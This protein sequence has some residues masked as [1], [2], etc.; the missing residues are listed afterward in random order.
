MRYGWLFIIPLVAIVAIVGVLYIRHRKLQAMKKKKNKKITY[1][2]IANT[3]SVRDLPEYKSARRTYRTLIIL[4]TILFATSITSL[5]VLA[6]R[7]IEITELRSAKENRDVMLCLDTSYSM[8]DAIGE[9]SEYFSS[10]LDKLNGERIGI[11]LFDGTYATISPLSDDYSA[12]KDIINNVQYNINTY[13]NVVAGGGGTSQIG[14]G[15]VGC[16][17]GFD[18]IGEAERSRSI[19]LVTDNKSGD[20]KLSLMDAAKYAKRFE[21]TIYGLDSN[22]YYGGEN[23]DE[24]LNAALLTGGAY[25]DIN[26]LGKETTVAGIVERILEQEAARYDGA[27]QLV[28]TD[29]PEIAGIVSAISLIAFLF[30]I[31]RLRL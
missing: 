5:T 15:V 21:I 17:D 12:L 30:I 7:P 11:T 25:Y 13:S 8:Y 14:T 22:S 9:T 23:Q 28:K 24:F 31:W 26:S 16:I 2:Q 19:I 10:I 6:S 29:T 18:R 20:T 4:A 3:R 27:K 1:A